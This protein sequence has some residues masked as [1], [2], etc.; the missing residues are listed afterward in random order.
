MQ[1]H[2]HRVT[3]T[4]GTAG[5]GLANDRREMLVGQGKAFARLRRL[6]GSAERMMRRR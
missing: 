5:I 1:P 2:D 6:G 3:I 4:G